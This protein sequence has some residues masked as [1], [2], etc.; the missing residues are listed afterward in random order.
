MRCSLAKG[1]A[2]S[3]TAALISA[4]GYEWPAKI[5]EAAKQVPKHVDY[6]WDV[7]PI[8]SQNCL[9]CHGNDEKKRKAGLR[10]D[11]AQY[12]YAPLPENPRKRAIV[13]GNPGQSELIRRILSSDSEVV[14]PPTSAHKTLTP[15]QVA[16]LGKWIEQGAEYK[17]HWAYIAPKEVKPSRGPF[18][19]RA[20]N[21]IDR[22]IYAKLE[23]RGMQPSP[24]ADPETLINRVTLDLTGLPPTL[25][26]VDAFVADNSPEAYEKLVDRLLASPAYAERQAGMWMDVARYSETDGKGDDAHGRFFSPYRDWLIQSFQE[27]MP[28]DRFATWQLAG[29]LLPN[30]TKAQILA[31]AFGRLGGRS[32]ENGIMNEEFRVEYRNERAELVG[33]AFLGLTVSCARCHDHKYD[34][35]SQKEY[36]SLTGFFNSI[37]EPGMYEGGFTKDR[38]SGPTLDWPT[39]I[40]Q[41][42]MDAAQREVRAAEE[43]YVAAKATAHPR[44][45]VA[46]ADVD[47]AIGI[48]AKAV[49]ELRSCIRSVMSE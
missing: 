23:E 8:L 37:P 44:L 31:T 2:I 24:Q 39:P 19:Q 36:Y 10:L 32:T 14:M 4:C 20:I 9:Q 6:N 26:D 41:Q 33:K 15:L 29:D 5:A 16:V 12:A 35:I 38:R 45:R 34:A 49:D 18:E 22:Y 28:Y 43:R 3:V 11:S 13:P 21:N 7:R 42:E 30:P 46:H 47:A 25:A 48:V 40:Q 27:N 1:F 17:A